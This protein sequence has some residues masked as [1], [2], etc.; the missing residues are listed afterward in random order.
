MKETAFPG[1]FKD[2]GEFFTIN[3][4]PGADVYGER[5]RMV[6]GVEYRHW[7]PRRSK[8]AAL[9]KKGCDV[10]PFSPESKVLYLGAA[11]GTTV[12]HLSDICTDGRIFAVEFSSRSFRKLVQLSASR[13]NIVPLMH[14]ANLPERYARYVSGVDVL[15]QDVSQ[16]NQVEI[17]LRNF[18]HFKPEVGMLMLKAR[19]VD[20]G[21][22]PRGVFRQARGELSV[23]GV[24]VVE[25]VELAPFEKDHICF[26]VVSS[27]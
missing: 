3:S 4:N 17:F 13:R 7:D 5:L 25:Q 15:Y 16:R 10:F 1:V 14:D 24:K 8:P 26:T 2:S 22:D 9:L 27:A 11:T 23:G 19:S 20:V 21:M 6:G 12:S 18:E